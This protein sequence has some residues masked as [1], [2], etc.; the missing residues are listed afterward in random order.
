MTAVTATG[1]AADVTAVEVAAVEAEAAVV[2]VQAEA[3]VQ[4]GHSLWGQR[5]TQEGHQVGHA[6]QERSPS[7]GHSNHSPG[8]GQ[9]RI[10]L[11]EDAES[12]GIQG[13]RRLLLLGSPRRDGGRRR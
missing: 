6:E 4:A 9:V 2:A 1:V 8:G 12:L 10:Q 5:P 3:A 13:I 11:Q 7:Q